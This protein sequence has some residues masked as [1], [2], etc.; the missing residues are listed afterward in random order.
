M[1]FTKSLNGATENT[2]RSGNN[3]LDMI[4]G[5]E[6]DYFNAP[7]GESQKATAPILLTKVDNNKPFT[8]IAK[9]T[10]QFNEMYDAGALYIYWDDSL[11][12]KFA[13][14]MDEIKN[15]R[16]VTVRT[17]QTSDDNNHSIIIQE[18]VYLKI[19]SDG[20]Q[21]GLYYSLDKEIW[22]LARLYKN[23]YPADIYV[24]ISTQSP[25]GEGNQTTFEDLSLQQI[26]VKDFRMGV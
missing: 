11:W 18:S 12:Q 16:I 2:L 22:N 1:E 5:R 3:R 8:F 15:T 9:L 21:I 25:I 7:D 4:S 14:E 17:N 10:P 24:G 19:S 20:K 23:D 26:S 6:T 13:F